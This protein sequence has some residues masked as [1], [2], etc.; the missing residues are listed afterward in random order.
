MPGRP[1]HMRATRRWLCAAG[2][3]LALGGCAGSAPLVR[4]SGVLPL[5]RVALLPLE[6]LALK[7][8]AGD[9]VTRVVYG[10]LAQSQRCE[11]AEPGDVEAGMRDL[12]IRT[13]GMLTSDQAAKLASR[14]NVRYLLTGTIL[15]CGMVRTPD[16]EVPSVGLS[17]RMLRGVDGRVTWNAMRVRTGDD[18]ETLFGWGREISLERLTQRALEDMLRKFPLPAAT[19]AAPDSGGS[20]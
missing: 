10:A 5:E 7:P 15:E 13:S 11:M 1:E 17:L 19:P 9:M 18:R 14:L 12:R 20:R 6:N 8:E 3:A 4:G 16:G 2:L